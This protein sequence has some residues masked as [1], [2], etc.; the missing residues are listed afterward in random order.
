[1]NNLWEFI[2]WTGWLFKTEP[3]IL[4][5]FLPKLETFTFITLFILIK[6]ILQLKSGKLK[7]HSIKC[8][9]NITS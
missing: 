2:T 6:E 9:L 5:A 3:A 8:K 1:M 7:V 4:N